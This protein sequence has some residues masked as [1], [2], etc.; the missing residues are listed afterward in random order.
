MKKRLLVSG[1]S[2]EDMNKK[3]KLN[4]E[5]LDFLFFTAASCGLCQG[6]DLCH[7]EVCAPKEANAIKKGGTIYKQVGKEFK[8]TFASLTCL[9]IRM[10]ASFKCYGTPTAK[11]N[12][13]GRLVVQITDDYGDTLKTQALKVASLAWGQVTQL[14]KLGTADLSLREFGHA[15]SVDHIDGNPS[16]N[17]VSNGLIMTKAEHHAKTEPSAEQ[18]AKQ[19]MNQSAP[20]TMTVFVSKGQPLLDS[21]RNPIVENYDHRKKV[22]IEYKLTSNDIKI[23]IRDKDMPTRNSEVKII[24]KDQ[25]CLAQFSW[26]DVP[27][28][29]GEI[30]KPVTAADHNTLDVT[31]SD[32][33]EYWVSNMS[34]FKFVTRSTQNARIKDFR[35]RERPKVKFM[36]KDPLFHRVVALVFHRKQMDKYIAEQKN[37]TGIVWTFAKSTNQPNQLEVDHIDFNP[38]NHYA[39]NLQFLTPQ[40]NTER[41]NSRPCIIWEIGKKDAQK[42]Y[43]SVVAAAKAMGYKSEMSVHT[44]LKNNTHKKWRGEY[45]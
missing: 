15:F 8:R 37:K 11:D 42:E 27:D 14:A 44:I 38:E 18:I 41:S 3:R 2:V 16:N 43:R 40:E 5:D 12:H 1:K 19:A 39:N 4:K 22:M 29:E 30:W 24:Y 28:I 36:G 33:N 9:F 13:T 20:C 31:I 7:P 10:R 23:S 45:L 34:R 32:Q 26:Y 25:D 21:E 35:G 17:D 6:C